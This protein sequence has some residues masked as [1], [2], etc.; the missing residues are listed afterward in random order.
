M[1]T[2]FIV[3]GFHFKGHNNCSHGYNSSALMAMHG[4]SSVLH[5]QKNAQLAKIKIP[6]IFM[7]YDSFV[8]LLKCLTSMMNVKESI[9]ITNNIK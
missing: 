3:D 8:E 4:I 2:I 7:R 1:D 5:E 6:S 9:K